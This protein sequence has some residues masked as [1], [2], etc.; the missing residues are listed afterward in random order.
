MLRKY[1]NLASELEE[2]LKMLEKHDKI[3]NDKFIKEDINDIKN[4]II[5]FI[6]RIDDFVEEYLKVT[7]RR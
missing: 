1:L 2:V 3:I 6:E 7:G 4:E 5:K